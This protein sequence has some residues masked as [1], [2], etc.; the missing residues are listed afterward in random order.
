M[1]RDFNAEAAALP[2]HSF[3]LAMHGYMLKTFR[4][5]FN[6]AVSALE[7]GCFEGHF[8]RLLRDEFPDLT[9]VDASEQCVAKAKAL[10]QQIECVLG[11][12]EDVQLERR[13]EAIFLT[14]VL[15]H[16]DDPVLVLKRCREWL[17]PMGRV[18]I[19]VPNGLSISRR[20]AVKLGLLPSPLHVM[21]HEAAHGHKRT[22]WSG[23][24]HADI[25][26]SGLKAVASGGIM[27]KPMGNAQIDRA[28]AEGIIDEKYLDACYEIGEE[29]G[30][31][32]ASLYAVCE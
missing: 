29:T 10:G 14:H 26:S 11:R 16:L 17:L 27:F 32:C 12:F 21:E 31:G 4:P 6:D 18:F 20:I 2:H 1:N 22:Y 19:A 13:Y 7:L 5:H 28:M 15:E 30:F 24:L 23:S 3:D 8:T 9:V 25:E